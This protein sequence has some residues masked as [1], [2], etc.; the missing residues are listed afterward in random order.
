MADGGLRKVAV[1][2]SK[3]GRIKRA[4]WACTRNLNLEKPDEHARI[5]AV[6]VLKPL[7][8]CLR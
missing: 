8:M 5:D 3:E 4:G 1:R 7:A 6:V 2:W